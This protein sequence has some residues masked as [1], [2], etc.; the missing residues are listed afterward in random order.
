MKS[1]PV[2]LLLNNPRTSRFRTSEPRHSA[3]RF[4]DKVIETFDD[5]ADK[6]TTTIQCTKDVE[7]DQNKNLNEDLLM[8]QLLQQS[9]IQQL[10]YFL[11]DFEKFSEIM[12]SKKDLISQ[13]K[14]Y[15]LISLMMKK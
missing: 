8:R 5:G 12:Y 1:C 4:K 13:L 10:I 7:N 3:P 15:V 14:D 6:T 2:P 11:Q 9:F